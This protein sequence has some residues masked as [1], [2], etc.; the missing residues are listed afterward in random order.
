[1]ADLF[2]EDPKLSQFGHRFASNGFDPT[3]VRPI[4][5][6]ATQTRSKS[7]PSV[8]PAPTAQNTPPRRLV[9]MQ[10]AYSPKRHL[11]A[12]ESDHE[13]NRPRKLARGESP[14]KGAAGRRVDQQKRTQQQHQAQGG[15]GYGSVHH[16][17]PPPP[18]PRDVL[19][20]LSIIPRA[21]TYYPATR[22]SP[23]E[24]VRLLKDTPLPAQSYA[25][26]RPPPATMPQAYSQGEVD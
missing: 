26:L 5:S 15:Q 22:F 20:L 12:D 9:D 3:A 25:Q 17:P 6:P 13:V 18:L 7:L 14:L 16:P 1:M 19:F 24:M 11:P 21:E 23:Q 8:E 4:I 10:H 2:P